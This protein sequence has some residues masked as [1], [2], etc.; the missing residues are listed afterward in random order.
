MAEDLNQLK[1]LIDNIENS[2]K[3]PELIEWMNDISAKEYGLV[4]SL[5]TTF[6]ESLNDIKFANSIFRCLQ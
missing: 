5:I 3:S 6:L 4:D 2:E 1:E